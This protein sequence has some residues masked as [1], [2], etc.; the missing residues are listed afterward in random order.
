MRF[1]LD[2]AIWR[3]YYEDRQDNLRPLGEFAFQLLKKAKKEKYE[4]LYSDLIVDELKRYIE[5]TLVR[6]MF[7]IISEEGLLKKVEIKRSQMIKA[8]EL[9][10]RLKIPFGDCLHDILAK[11]HK[12]IM[13]TRDKHFLDIKHL[14]HVAKPEELI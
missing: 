12:A 4:I 2:T 9:K 13:V 11:D 8:R 1:Y 10:N 5:E 7:A 3:D 14:V 6:E